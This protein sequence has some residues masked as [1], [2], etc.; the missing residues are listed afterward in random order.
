MTDQSAL[1][2]VLVRLGEL[3]LTNFA[4]YL[5]NRIMGR[6]NARLRDEME[7]IPLQASPR[8]IRMVAF[9]GQTGRDIVPLA[10]LLKVELP[11]SRLQTSLARQIIRADRDVRKPGG[12]NR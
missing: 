9:I 1:P 2:K 4:P 11:P 6:Y 3:G 5:M 7:L 8:I 10:R 12:I